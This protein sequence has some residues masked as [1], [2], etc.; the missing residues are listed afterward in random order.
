MGPPHC[1]ATPQHDSRPSVLPPHAALRL[2]VLISHSYQVCLWP[3][4]FSHAEHPS[5]PRPGMCPSSPG[6][7]KPTGCFFT[8]L[9]L[10]PGQSFPSCMACRESP[11]RC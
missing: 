11:S 8:R 6:R 1:G 4:C 5:L 9:F 2:S 10:K 7:A 3:S